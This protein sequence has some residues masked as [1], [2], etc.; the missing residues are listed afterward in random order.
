MPVEVAAASFAMTGLPAFIFVA[1]TSLAPRPRSIAC[2]AP[3]DVAAK[4]VA[5][6]PV[7]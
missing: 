5:R 6:M 1:A 7:L 4:P 2:R 3:C